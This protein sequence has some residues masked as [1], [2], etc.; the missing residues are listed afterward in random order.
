MDVEIK[1][2]GQWQIAS[3]PPKLGRFFLAWAVRWPDRIRG[4]GPL[5]EPHADVWF[6]FGR[7]REDAEEKLLKDLVKKGL[8]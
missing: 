3:R 4:D 1:Q 2:Y 8:M 5:S 7:T 6:E